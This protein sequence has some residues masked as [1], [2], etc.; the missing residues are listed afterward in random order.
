MAVTPVT[1]LA[2]IGATPLQRTAYATPVLVTYGAVNAL[3]AGGSTG[4][5]EFNCTSGMSPIRQR[6]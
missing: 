4:V 5:N 2:H 3:T 6:C 1:A